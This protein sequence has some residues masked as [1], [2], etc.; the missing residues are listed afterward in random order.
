[1]Q[2]RS[3]REAHQFVSVVEFNNPDSLYN[4]FL[5]TMLALLQNFQTQQLHRFA[6]LL[7]RHLGNQTVDFVHTL[8]RGKILFSVF[9]HNYF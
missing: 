7:S 5:N 8:N 2:L 9:W 6:S 4:Q 1:M 3:K